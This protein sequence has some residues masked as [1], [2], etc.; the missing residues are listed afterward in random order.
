MYMKTYE[1]ILYL[2]KFAL[3]HLYDTRIEHTL[4]KFVINYNI[5]KVI[6]QSKKKE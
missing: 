5:A 6:S 1:Y 3:Q 4:I 2:M